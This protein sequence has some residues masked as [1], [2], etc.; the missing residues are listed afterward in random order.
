MTGALSTNS[1]AQRW[2]TIL[3]SRRLRQLRREHGLSQEQLAAVAGMSLT[4]IR[5][6]ERQ[7]AA[8]CRTRTL[9]RLAAALGEDPERLTPRDPTLSGPPSHVPVPVTRLSRI[10]SSRPSGMAPHTGRTGERGGPVV[11][12]AITPATAGSVRSSV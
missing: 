2:T 9:G 7:P 11:H 1:L 4:T 12:Q 5:R 8:P 6:L 3:D 10:P